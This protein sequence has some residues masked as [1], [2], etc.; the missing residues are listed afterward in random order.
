MMTIYRSP[1]K[2]SLVRKIKI[3]FVFLVLL[4]ITDLALIFAFRLWIEMTYRDGVVAFVPSS[5]YHVVIHGEPAASGYLYWLGRNE[6]LLLLTPKSSKYDREV[7]YINMC[8]Y[9][10]EIGLPESANFRR[11]P[12][13]GGAL[14]QRKVFEGYP[15]QGELK[16]D[17]QVNDHEVHL[18]IKGFSDSAQKAD[19]VTSP[20]VYER[21]MPLAYQREIILKETWLQEKLGD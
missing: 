11:V 14:V 13:L 17:W 21:M 15:F 9:P 6:H 16:A 5:P 3:L 7:Y 12:F 2:K 8:G 18:H 19:P 1:S 10:P 20:D 4:L